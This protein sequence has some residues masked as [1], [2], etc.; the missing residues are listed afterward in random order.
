MSIFHSWMESAANLIPLLT[1]SLLQHVVQSLK[2]MET[3]LQLPMQQQQQHLGLIQLRL[4][5]HRLLHRLAMSYASN[6]KCEI[7]TVF[8]SG[9]GSAKSNI[10]NI[11]S[12]VDVHTKK[13]LFKVMRSCVAVV[14]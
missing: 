3:A 12:V 7:T 4:W 1:P 11:S 10:R 8:S 9:V 14:L 13:H 2:S 6:V 5:L